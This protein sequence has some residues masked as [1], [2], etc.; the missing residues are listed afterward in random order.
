MGIIYTISLNHNLNPAPDQTGF[1]H[2]INTRDSGKQD[3][4][5]NNA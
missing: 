2:D 3:K 1:G 4:E 5:K